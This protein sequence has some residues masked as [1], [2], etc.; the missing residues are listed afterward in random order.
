MKVVAAAVAFVPRCHDPS[1]LQH[2][3]SAVCNSCGVSPSWRSKLEAAL[4]FA[5]DLLQEC[6]SGTQRLEVRAG[7]EVQ[8][9]YLVRRPSSLPLTNLS[10]FIGAAVSGYSTEDH[11]AGW[12]FVGRLGRKT[13]GGVNFADS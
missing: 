2:L 6:A 5:S 11:F 8:E 1:A 10:T 7:G 3:F 9:Q 12:P 13:G 4:T